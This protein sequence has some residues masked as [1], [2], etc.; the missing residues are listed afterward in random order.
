MYL[1]VRSVQSESS[2]EQLNSLTEKCYDQR[3]IQA[4]PRETHRRVLGL[5]PQDVTS[6]Y[7]QKSIG[8]TRFVKTIRVTIAVRSRRRSSRSVAE[9]E[10]YL[11]PW[12]ISRGGI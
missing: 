1:P 8:Q 4:S 10:G 12:A 3:R 9:L 7:L 11:T 6:S 5:S 2:V